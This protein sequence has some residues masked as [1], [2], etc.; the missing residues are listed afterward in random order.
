MFY[1]SGLDGRLRFVDAGFDLEEEKDMVN[2][3]LDNG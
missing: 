3:G 2:C 1:A